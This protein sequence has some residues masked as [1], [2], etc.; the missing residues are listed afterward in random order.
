MQFGVTTGVPARRQP[1]KKGTIRT[2]IDESP[3]G[4]PSQL[5]ARGWKRGFFVRPMR[6]FQYF[7]STFNVDSP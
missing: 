2:K 1:Q 5:F 4:E 3:E 7:S 6:L